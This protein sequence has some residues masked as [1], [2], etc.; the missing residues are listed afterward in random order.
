MKLTITELAMDKINELKGSS[1]PY[2]LLQ[3]DTDGCGCGVNGVPTIDFVADK[4]ETHMEVENES[5]PTIVDKMQSVF[6]AENMKLD[7]VNGMFRLSGP[8]GM[9]NPFI[10]TPVCTI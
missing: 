7:F 2:L 6:F 5:I 9:L 3:Y 10:S 8:E 4:Y 1:N